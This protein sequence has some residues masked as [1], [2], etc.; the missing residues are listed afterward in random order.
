MQLINARTDDHIWAEEYNRN[1]SDIFNVQTEVAKKVAEA[2][3]ATFSKTAEAAIGA[4]PTNS[5]EAFKHY[6]QGLH[7]FRSYWQR[8][9]P[10]LLALSEEHFKTALKLDKKFS[11]AHTGLAKVNMQYVRTADEASRKKLLNSAI[12]YLEKA[13]KLDPYNGWA[14]SELAVYQWEWQRDSSAA[15]KS[16]NTAIMLEPNNFTIYDSYFQFEYVLGNCQAIEPLWQNMS[17]IRPHVK[18]PFNVYHLKVLKCQKNFQ[19]IANIA[20]EYWNTNFTVV[21]ARLFFYG[22]LYTNN[23]K[24]AHEMLSFIVEKSKMG[25]QPIW[26]TGI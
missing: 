8:N 20:D 13:I 19:Q 9:D 15:R 6:L 1:W 14:H 11:N 24:R 12:K 16:F 23:Y 7:A 4:K 18:Y 25:P 21:N 3:S 22:Y 17:K 2:L 5:M 10:A 26:L